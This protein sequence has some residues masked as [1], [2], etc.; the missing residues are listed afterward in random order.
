M[1]LFTAPP[2]REQKWKSLFPFL[3]LPQLQQMAIVLTAVLAQPDAAHA[4]QKIV[5]IVIEP[6]L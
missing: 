3:H 5:R 6:E 1:K 2:A 4:L